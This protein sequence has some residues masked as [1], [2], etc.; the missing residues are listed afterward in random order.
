VSDISGLQPDE[1]AMRRTLDAFNAQMEQIYG[2]VPQVELPQAPRPD[3]NAFRLAAGTAAQA[4]IEKIR[5]TYQRL[6]TNL[7]G[8]DVDLLQRDPFDLPS[9]KASAARQSADAITHTK[10]YLELAIS[11]GPAT[12]QRSRE[13]AA[14]VTQAWREMA[15]KDTT[16]FEA[17]TRNAITDIP[18][19][20]AQ[21]DELARTRSELEQEQQAGP[22]A[23]RGFAISSALSRIEG[24]ETLLKLRIWAS[25][26]GS[27]AL[28]F[29]QQLE[30]LDTT[31]SQAANWMWRDI[32]RVLLDVEARRHRRNGRYRWMYGAV[33]VGYAALV[34]ALGVVV[35]AVL[36]LTP[37]ASIATSLA[38]AFILWIADR[39]LVSP[40][41]ERW[42]RRQNIRLLQYELSACAI[43]LAKIRSVQVEIDAMADYTGVSH[44]PLLNPALLT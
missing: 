40:R 6:A 37:I 38:A 4:D 39:R 19:A 3:I 44:L 15:A 28:D 43:T 29:M 20:Q 13:Y 9:S 2:P 11:E 31:M 16:T 14:T 7:D 10:E 36:A 18:A 8:I 17:Q 12:E 27:N 42:N 41:L 1:S 25:E 30:A 5:E 35:D 32:A 21:L 23:K 22:D 26:H 33:L 24:E 34:V